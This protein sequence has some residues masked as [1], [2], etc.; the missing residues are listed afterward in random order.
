MSFQCWVWSLCI[1]NFSIQSN[2]VAPKTLLYV[3]SWLW[4]NVKTALV[5]MCLIILAEYHEAYMNCYFNDALLLY[6]F[7]RYYHL[8]IAIY[9]C[10][11]CIICRCIIC[12][13]LC[14][15]LIYLNCVIVMS[16]SIVVVLLI[17]SNDIIS[18]FVC[19]TACY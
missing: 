1:N 3:W 15:P 10:L 8:C 12:V 19:V 7:L 14:V 18:V 2:I 13:L 6:L 11:W 5:I 4:Y 16:C 17:V 9:Q